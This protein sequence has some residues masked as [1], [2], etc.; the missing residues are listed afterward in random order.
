[1][2][3]LGLGIQISP[4]LDE[5]D[6]LGWK[7]RVLDLGFF[8]MEFRLNQ[9]TENQKFIF[10]V[11]CPH[12]THDKKIWL[13]ITEALVNFTVG[14]IYISFKGVQSKIYYKYI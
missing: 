1:M 11:F 7:K 4:K 9:I 10:S 12:K 13:E 14:Y 6:N 5:A 2:L 8:D 3:Y